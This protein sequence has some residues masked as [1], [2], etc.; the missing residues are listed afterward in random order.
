MHTSVTAAVLFAPM[1]AP[2]GFLSLTKNAREAVAA[3]FSINATLMVVA[4]WPAA[5]AATP[6]TE[7][8]STPAFAVP[9]TVSY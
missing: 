6:E 1:A 8:K 4:A 2:A 7:R 5:N 9:A 3:E